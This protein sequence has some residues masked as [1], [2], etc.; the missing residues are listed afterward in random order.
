LCELEI[1]F[2]LT[3]HL[4]LAIWMMMIKMEIVYSAEEIWWDLGNWWK[5]SI[6]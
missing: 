6:L 3:R 5:L 4:E 2:G 1:Y